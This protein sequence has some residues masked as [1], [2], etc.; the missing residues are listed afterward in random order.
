[1]VVV[2]EWVNRP[3]FYMEICWGQQRSCFRWCHLQLGSSKLPCPS[4]RRQLCLCEWLGKAGRAE[5]K[6]GSGGGETVFVTHF[7]CFKPL[8]AGGYMPFYGCKQS[9]E[10]L[11]SLTLN[12]FETVFISFL[13]QLWNI[14]PAPPGWGSPSLSKLRTSQAS[15]K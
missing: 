14:T 3:E 11:V 13:Y 10:A 7:D 6:S 8:Q 5:D 4:Q 9:N 12:C 15:W 1:M 2:D